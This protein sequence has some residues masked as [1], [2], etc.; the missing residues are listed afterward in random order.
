MEIRSS[1]Q[2]HKI[3]CEFIHKSILTG[4][5]NECLK[6]IKGRSKLPGEDI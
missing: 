6:K 2:N 4:K 5:K 1:I 3:R